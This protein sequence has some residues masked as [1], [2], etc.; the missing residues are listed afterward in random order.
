MATINGATGLITGLS[1]GTATMT[2]TVVGTGGCANV[3]ATRIVTVT[4]PPVNGTLSGIQIVCQGN[5]RS[6]SST[7][8]GGTWSSSDATIAT[9]TPATGVVTGISQGAANITYTIFGT[10]GCPNA[11][12]DRQ[13]TVNP[14]PQLS[15]SGINQIC[16]T[17]TSNVPLIA[18]VA[19]ADFTW[20]VSQ[21]GVSGANNGSGDTISQTLTSQNGGNAIYTVTPSLNGCIGNSA[22]VLINVKP[23]PRPTLIDGLICIELN[24]GNAAQ[25]YLFNAGLNDSSH[26]FQWFFNGSPIQNE[27]SATL[28]VSETGE[29][30][31]IAT[32]TITGCISSEVFGTVTSSIIADSF[33]TSVTEAFENNPYIIVNTPAGTGPF[34]YQLD[35]GAFQSSNVFYNVPSGLHT[36]TV[37]DDFGCTN[38]SGSLFILNYPHFFT[39][40]GDTYND[41]W[42]I[43]DLKDQP[44]DGIYIFDR[45]GK[46]VKQISPAGKGWD[47]TMNGYELPS[48]DYWFTV[49]YFDP[50]TNQ[51]QTFKS[52]FSLKR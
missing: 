20:T 22:F 40:N 10:G 43:W 18:T 37:K 41:T 33:T 45:Y 42:N 19:G 23:L 17:N 28:A 38:L 3:T 13:I 29:Y 46:F 4:A 51:K 49:D 47:G 25:P 16:S 48:T 8:F 5:T 21:N 32:D 24:T 26:D 27:N 9:V 14:T 1:A 7:V 6:F 52:H 36:I 31:V 35:L 34:Q 44:S 30:S 2:Y 50:N 11:T 39:P 15:N 12:V